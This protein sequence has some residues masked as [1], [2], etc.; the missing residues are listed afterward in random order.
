[1]ARKKRT[2]R[3]FAEPHA[4]H[5]PSKPKSNESSRTR[6]IAEVD[7]QSERRARW[8][9]AT[10]TAVVVAMLAVVY[11]LWFLSYPVLPGLSGDDGQPISRGQYLTRVLLPELWLGEV[12]GAGQM[13]LGI[14][15][16]LPIAVGAIVWLSVAFGLGRVVV[17]RAFAEL[18]RVESMVLSTLAG[19]AMLS[20][21]VLIVGLAGGSNSRWALVMPV[22]VALAV[23]WVLDWRKTSD[24]DA[25]LGHLLPTSALRWLPAESVAAGVFGQL[26][27]RV[28]LVFTL[29]LAV[30]YVLGAMMPPYEFDVV[31]YHLQGAK[32]FFQRGSIGFNDHNV[33]L[34]MPLGLE[35]HSLAAMSLVNGEDGWWLGGLIGKTII[36]AHALLAAAFAGG[37]VAR[38]TGSWWCGWSVAGVWLAVPGN[39]HV[40]TSGLID[41]A[42]GAYI[43]ACVVGVTELWALS[44]AGDAVDTSGGQRDNRFGRSYW[45]VFAI[46][47]FAGAAAAAKY[48]GLVYA[49]MP[50]M[51]AVGC[52][53]VR[54]MRAG[55]LSENQVQL[56]SKSLDGRVLAGRVLAA[57]W[58]AALVCGLLLTCLPWYAKNAVLASNPVYPLAYDWFG[59]VGLDASRAE[60]WS[61]AHRV[62][63]DGQSGSAYSLNALVGSIKNVFVASEF[64]QPSLMILLMCGV[65]ASL[66][67][68]VRGARSLSQHELWMWLGWSMW[69][70]MV[71][72]TATHRIDRF[73]L[74]AVSLW[75]VVAGAGLLWLSQ[76][77]SHALATI[78]VLVGLA[79]GL[80]VN[81]SPVIGD[82]RFFV[83]IE[84]LRTDGGDGERVGR[85]NRSIAWCNENLS[86]S[87]TKL[88]LVGEAR[89]FDFRMPIIYST[90]FDVSPAEKWL[91]GVTSDRAAGE[92]VA[93]NPVSSQV[94]A[95]RASLREAGVTHL[96]VN[97]SELARYRS[98][99]NYGFS[100]W[101]TR[102]DLAGLVEAGLLSRV[103]WPMESETA[104]LYEVVLEGR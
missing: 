35:M 38:K 79:Y 72:W 57:R 101:P 22:L 1:M 6:I 49:V 41:A 33:Y 18:T 26:A 71:W 48:P 86:W 70:V 19:L 80:V 28:V 37:F 5:V 56:E 73:W 2:A 96:L 20:T 97:W 14:V 52:I 46:F 99:G 92:S 88:L 82:N 60:Q 7:D 8:A 58:F 78:L 53:A 59:G 76:R 15:D 65:V 91:R 27:S 16:R 4:G 74:P 103:S 40:A 42:I 90:C 93:A 89:A 61:Q 29:A 95:A 39:A 68:K 32:E 12:T 75:A 85:L 51:V 24:R 17:R 81:S 102:G 77:A 67:L 10:V 11:L 64:A 62:P 25:R 9:I 21:I 50:A 36:G 83:A 87:E 13:P 54:W 55:G 69:M 43:L 44:S 98:P 34:N 23:A 31:E 104:E 3:E 66:L 47:L 63:I 45:L 100:D 30:V 84:A 94:E